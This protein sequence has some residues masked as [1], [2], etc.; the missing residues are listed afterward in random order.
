MEI[1]PVEKSNTAA[2]KFRLKT[3]QQIMIRNQY[4]YISGPVTDIADLNRPAFADMERVIKNRGYLPINPHNIISAD[5]QANLE[6]DRA[7]RV[8]VKYLLPAALVIML[9][10]W[11]DSTGA[12]FEFITAKTLNI[13]VVDSDFNYLVIPTAQLYELFRKIIV[14]IHQTET[15]QLTNYIHPVK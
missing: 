12:I 1:A 14:K 2:V 4:V 3:G 9:P 5:D 10:G 11:H 13:P 7:M 8:D 6:W 15:L